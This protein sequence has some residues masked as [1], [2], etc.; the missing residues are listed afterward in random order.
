MR[1]VVL[2]ALETVTADCLG[3]K[4]SPLAPSTGEV[5]ISGQAFD[6]MLGISHF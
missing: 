6:S 5:Q 4:A 3:Y 2:L 1:L